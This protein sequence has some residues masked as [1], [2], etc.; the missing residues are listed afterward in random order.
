LVPAFDDEAVRDRFQGQRAGRD[1]SFVQ[2]RITQ[3]RDARSEVVFE[4]QLVSLARSKRLASPAVVLRKLGWVNPSDRPDDLR[5]I[6]LEDIRFNELF[7]VFGSDQIEARAVVTPSVMQRLA[8]LQS[9]LAATHLSVA[10]VE[11]RLLAAIDSGACFEVGGMFST[12]VDRTRARRVVRDLET[13]LAMIDA[14]AA[15]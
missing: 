15:L 3:N 7:A 4:G 2:A 1:F 10:F 5:A 12:L 13:V 8:D 9:D 6:G 11:G 14:L